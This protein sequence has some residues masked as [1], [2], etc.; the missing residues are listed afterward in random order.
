MAVE[1]DGQAGMRREGWEVVGG[2]REDE[3][4]IW[5]DGRLLGAHD[6]ASTHRVERS[7]GRD[8]STCAQRRLR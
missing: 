7:I 4:H 2:G 1:D 8:V 5:R 6:A 3:K